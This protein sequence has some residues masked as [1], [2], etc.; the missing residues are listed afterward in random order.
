MLS[1]S[2]PRVPYLPLPLHCD[3][4]AMPPRKLLNCDWLCRYHA[5]Y[6]AT[7]Q[8]LSVHE[9]RVLQRMDRRGLVL[10]IR[11]MVHFVALFR[12]QLSRILLRLESQP[13]NADEVAAL[14]SGI[15][16]PV[17]EPVTDDDDGDSTP[18][19]S[20]SAAYAEEHA[21]AEAPVAMGN[22]PGE[23]LGRSRPPRF[24][25]GK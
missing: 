20:A 9:T 16:G 1:H 12:F 19:A 25:A 23:E 5:Y 17:G 24:W 18:K 11:W 13:L 6:A 14:R 15:F 4:C 3:H 10:S 8:F 2:I 22:R 7:G 21:S